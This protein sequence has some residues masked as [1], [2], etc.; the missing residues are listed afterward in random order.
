MQET[1]NDSQ[2]RP[3]QSYL[4]S[5]A[6]QTLSSNFV[7]RHTAMD[8]HNIKDLFGS[9]KI[10]NQPQPK[11][12]SAR[13]RVRGRT[14]GPR[15]SEASNSM[16]KTQGSIANRGSSRDFQQGSV[17]IRIN[18]KNQVKSGSMVLN[19]NPEKENIFKNH[20]KD[21][22]VKNRAN[23]QAEIQNSS[24][25]QKTL[26][27]RIGAQTTNDLA[28]AFFKDRGIGGFMNI[29]NRGF[30]SDMELRRRLQDLENL[31]LQLQLQ[32]LSS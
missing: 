32:N 1:A 3:N 27:M 2:H 25:S 13:N 17:P 20:A 21:G 11:P 24:T 31:V 15:P 30:T 23:S 18:R 26:S 8:S 28:S 9:Y 29:E 5:T 22:Q 7:G 16:I 10:Y 6:Q 19:G 4:R 12:R 14:V